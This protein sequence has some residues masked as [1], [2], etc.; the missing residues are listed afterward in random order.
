M[1]LIPIGT[2]CV[3]VQT[4]FPHLMGA[5]CTVVGYPNQGECPWGST[6]EF[7]VPVDTTKPLWYGK[8]EHVKP[9]GP[10]PQ[11]QPAPPVARPIDEPVTA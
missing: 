2:P 5:Y 1:R 3:I 4:G 7:H 8:A 11:E 9:T 6:H 10:P